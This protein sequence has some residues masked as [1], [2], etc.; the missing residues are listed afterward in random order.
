MVQ[1]PDNINAS[2]STSVSFGGGFVDTTPYPHAGT[3]A[4]PLL[5]QDIINEIGKIISSGSL[6]SGVNDIY[7]IFTANGINSC[8]DQAMTLCTFA[9]TL[10]PSGFCSYHSYFQSA[11]LVPFVDMPVNP[12]GITGGCQILRERVPEWRLY[13]RL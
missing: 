10:Q 3:T 5:G 13:S 6:P 11:A 2:P 12:S 8:E 1:Y 4:S 7:Y 9:T